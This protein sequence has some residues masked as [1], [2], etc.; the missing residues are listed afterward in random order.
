MEIKLPFWLDK[1][2][3]RKIAALFL[4]WWHWAQIFLRYP[5]ETQDES[6]CSERVLNLIAYQRDITRLDGEPLDLFRKR[7]KYAFLNAKDAGS[8]QGFARIFE[9]LGIGYIEQDER[10]DAENWDVI[11]IKLTDKQISGRH[12]LLMQIVRQYGRT[13]RRYEFSTING[14]EIVI[15]HGEFNHTYQC[16]PVSI[17]L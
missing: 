12:N 8:K 7:V 16:F 10:F 9:R 4:K 17:N 13:C 14:Q 1:G 2:E 15:R 3:I 6:K 5:L 11:R